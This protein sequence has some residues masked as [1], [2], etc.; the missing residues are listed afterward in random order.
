MR[1]PCPCWLSGRPE[2]RW[3]ALFP[4]L[5]CCSSG[6]SLTSWVGGGQTVPDGGSAGAQRLRAE[7]E[8]SQLYHCNIGYY[9]S[10][11]V[12]CLTHL[13]GIVTVQHQSKWLNV[14]VK[15]K[16]L[17][18]ALLLFITGDA[19]LS[20]IFWAQINSKWSEVFYLM[21]KIQKNTAPLPLNPC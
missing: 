19:R 7:E 5:C 13:R 20:T 15:L 16:S 3:S 12:Q 4:P 6:S 9:H 14:E 8:T 21:R 18:R 1:L 11:K 10:S 17:H 2:C